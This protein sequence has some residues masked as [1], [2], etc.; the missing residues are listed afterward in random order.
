MRVTNAWVT[1]TIRPEIKAM[2]ATARARTVDIFSSNDSGSGSWYVVKNFEA[3]EW[4]LYSINAE[5]AI[6]TFELRASTSPDFPGSAYHIEIDDRAET[7]SIV[8]PDTGGWDNY[9]WIGTKLVVGVDPPLW[10][11]IVVDKGSFNLNAIRMTLP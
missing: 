10:L 8:L 2:R 1:T 6:Y 7:G 4:L 11:R 5:P 9:Q 3:G